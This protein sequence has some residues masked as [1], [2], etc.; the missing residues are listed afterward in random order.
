[1]SAVS[2]I[3]PGMRSKL[4]TPSP[5]M[6]HGFAQRFPDSQLDRSIRVSDNDQATG[7]FP[8]E[9]D[10][11][12]GGV[13]VPSSRPPRRGVAFIQVTGVFAH[14]VKVRSAPVCGVTI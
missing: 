5:G 3:A 11:E 6:A 1:M 13:G 7:D 2:E 8:T 4:C 14:Y 9:I 10:D 12:L